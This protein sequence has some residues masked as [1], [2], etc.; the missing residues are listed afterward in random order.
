MFRY[1]VRYNDELENYTIKTESG[2]VVAANYSEAADRVVEFYGRDNIVVLG[3]YEID[4][5]IA[6]PEIRDMFNENLDL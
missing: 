5:V 1:K 2:I 4:Q 6:E 3:L